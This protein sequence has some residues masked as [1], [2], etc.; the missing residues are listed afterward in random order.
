MA[1]TDQGAAIARHQRKHV[2]GCHDILASTFRVDGN[3][4]GPGAVVRGDTGR[5]TLP[6]FDRDGKRRFVP[7]LVARR[8]QRQAETFHPLAGHRQADQPAGVHGHEIDAL[9]R[10]HLRRDA[11]VALVLPVLVINQDEHPARPGLGG[12]FL[13]RGQ[14][15]PVDIP[16]LV[17]YR[18]SRP[19]HRIASVAPHSARSCQFPHSTGHPPPS[20]RVSLPPAYA[21]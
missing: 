11:Q 8:H 5:Y 20:I 21:E 9:G 16:Q 15:S 3:R 10:R 12:H 19:L 18:H 2:S 7:G 17:R 1:G 4:D 14:G 6:R 13:D